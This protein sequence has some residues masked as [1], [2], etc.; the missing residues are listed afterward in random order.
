MEERRMKKQHL[1]TLDIGLIQELHRRVARGHRSQ[2]VETAVRNRLK[3]E[4]DYDASDIEIKALA[5]MLVN[6]LSPNPDGYEKLVIMT[7]LEWMNQ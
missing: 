4:E 7:I 6:R 2:F 3:N 1:F 5:A